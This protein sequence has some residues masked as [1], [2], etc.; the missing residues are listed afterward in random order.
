MKN[1]KRTIISVEVS[2]RH[3]HLSQK[4]LEKLFGQKYKLNKLR[5]LSQK[6]EF[7][8][9]ETVS[10]ASRVKGFIDKVR[11]LGPVRKETQVELAQTDVIKLGIEAPL[12]VSGDLQ[13]VKPVLEVRGPKGKIMA[14]AIV[15]KRHV[16]CSPAEAKKIGLKNG[17]KV[18]IEIMGERGL[19]FDNVVVRVAP[20]MVMSCHIDTDEANAAG[21]G[22][23]CG[24]GKLISS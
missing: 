11:V 18:K 13:K 5:D 1:Q 4:D 9:K 21:L 19:V 17:Q 7:A 6:G 23:I 22:K 12:A 16:H 14:K 3:I 24:V 2:A 10:L 8:S 20:K 15:A